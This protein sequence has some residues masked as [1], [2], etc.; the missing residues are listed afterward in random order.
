M[1]TL[2]GHV[3]E[4]AAFHTQIPYN[5]CRHVT[6]ILLQPYL[7]QPSPPTFYYVYNF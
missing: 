6:K 5:L 2:H 1:G 4:Q 3:L 7:E